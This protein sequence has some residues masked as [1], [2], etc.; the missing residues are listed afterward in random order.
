MRRLG[1]Q[2][3]ANILSSRSKLRC[4]DLCRQAVMEG[5]KSAV[6]SC[7][8]EVPTSVTRGGDARCQVSVAGVPT[9]LSL[10]IGPTAVS[11]IIQSDSSSILRSYKVFF[12][13]DWKGISQTIRLA[14]TNWS[15]D[16]R[17]S[18][19]ARY[20]ARHDRQHPNGLSSPESFDLFLS[21]P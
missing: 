16:D 5:A 11:R 6:V 7:R 3:G 20:R 14:A 19:I 15:V 8:C 18:P 4:Q 17:S 9:S 13:R 2:K 21:S 12:L 10:Y 1:S